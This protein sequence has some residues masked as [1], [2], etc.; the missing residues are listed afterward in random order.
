[1]V[2]APYLLD[3]NILLRLTKP[4]SP[5]FPLLRS[6]FK[7]F[8]IQKT[9]LY[10]TSQNLIEFWNVLTRPADR[11]GYGLTVEDA[12]K[13]ARY[14]EDSF[15]LLSSNDAVHRE[16]RRLVVTYGVS[17][18]QV[19]DAH[20]VAVMNSY[21]IRNLITLNTRDFARYKEITAIH[22]NQLS[23]PGPRPIP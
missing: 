21:G 10:Y 20:L 19:H 4:R 2:D 17:G 3:T 16:W 9:P 11:N 14:I 1:M 18:T 22:P 6:V 12:D 7:F 8:S 13:E 15:F 23:I 5:E